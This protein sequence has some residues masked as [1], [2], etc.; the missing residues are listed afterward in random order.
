MRVAMPPA[1]P[2]PSPPPRAAAIHVSGCA[3]SCAHRG[4]AALTLVGRD[5]RYDLIRDGGA[6]EKPALAGLTIAEVIA[7]LQ[8]AEGE[9]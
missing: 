6:S 5:G 9:P 7:L 8:S 3:K 2:P 1:L 4:A